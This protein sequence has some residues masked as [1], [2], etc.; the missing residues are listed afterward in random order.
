MFTAAGSHNGRVKRL[1]PL[2]KLSVVKYNTLY[3]CVVLTLHFTPESPVVCF[4]GSNILPH[5]LLPD[6]NPQLI[7]SQLLRGLRRQESW[8]PGFRC[9]IQVDHT[10]L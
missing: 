10:L 4:P 7:H 8:L 9:R 2:G 6:G 1:Y 3:P 5:F